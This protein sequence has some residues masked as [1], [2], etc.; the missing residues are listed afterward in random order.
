[1]G[2]GCGGR[3]IS[4]KRMIPRRNPAS[5]FPNKEPMATSGRL[6]IPNG[7]RI[8]RN[9]GSQGGGAPCRNN[10]QSV[11]QTASQLQALSKL[12]MLNCSLACGLAEFEVESSDIVLSRCPRH[13]AKQQGDERRGEEQGAEGEGIEVRPDQ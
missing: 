4:T 6:T 11:S 5:A 7:I 8:A 12:R 13:E 1:M 9:S 10:P 2:A 3:I